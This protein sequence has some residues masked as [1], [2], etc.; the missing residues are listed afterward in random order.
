[1]VAD[2][3]ALVLEELM[4]GAEPVPQVVA[5]FAATLLIHAECAL[6]DCVL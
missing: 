2:K 3:A 5:I 6:S 1:V 4:L